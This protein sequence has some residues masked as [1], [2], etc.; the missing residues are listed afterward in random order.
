MQHDLVLPSRANANVDNP[1]TTFN[2]VKHPLTATAVLT[3][4][5]LEHMGN[6]RFEPYPAYHY[7]A[8]PPAKKSIKQTIRFCKPCN[9]PC[10]HVYENGD[11]CVRTCQ[12]NPHNDAFLPCDCL[13]NHL[14]GSPLSPPVPPPV[15]VVPISHAFSVW[16]TDPRGSSRETYSPPYTSF[17][18][19]TR[20]YYTPGERPTDRIDG[21]FRDERRT[22]RGPQHASN[23]SNTTACSMDGGTEQSRAVLARHVRDRS[24]SNRTIRRRSRSRQ[25]RTPSECA[26]DAAPPTM[27]TIQQ[28]PKVTPNNIGLSRMRCIEFWTNVWHHGKQT[29]GIKHCTLTHD[30]HNFPAQDWVQANIHE[31]DISIAQQRQHDA[32]SMLTQLR[33]NDGHHF[34]I[35]AVIREA[36]PV[37]FNCQACNIKVTIP[38]DRIRHNT[39][40]LQCVWC[41]TMNCWNCL[42][43]EWYCPSCNQCMDQDIKPDHGSGSDDRTSTEL[44][45]SSDIPVPDD[46]P[47]P[48][49]VDM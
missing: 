16:N 7:R 28:R 1:A 41:K 29:C 34:K 6:D 23:H 22:K 40:N 9:D 11:P 30:T 31:K 39:W 8:V 20:R 45:P 15:E 21:I 27:P 36:N 49:A 44:S 24:R 14:P 32:D 17:D 3:P 18:N 19:G 5:R 42:D 38:I 37:N 43:D 46:E 35:D 2:E 33:K 10:T 4:V 25:R 48:N 26:D 12:I 47:T 13:Q